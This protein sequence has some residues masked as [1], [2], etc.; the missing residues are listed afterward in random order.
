[1]INFKRGIY[2]FFTIFIVGFIFYNSLQNGESSSQASTFVLNF[3]NN[4]LSHI[5]LNYDF[6]GHFIRKLAHFVEFFAYGVFLML[7]FEAFT[8]KIFSIIGFPLFFAIL[9]PVID[10]YIQLYSVGRASS[11][12][13]VLLDFSGATTGIFL[14]VAV[15]YIIKRINKN[16]YKYRYRY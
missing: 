15:L 8:K 2:L 6:S 9:V 7:T 10:E 4:F 14:V 3:I 1:M 13:D 11:V 12:K 5:G 16:K